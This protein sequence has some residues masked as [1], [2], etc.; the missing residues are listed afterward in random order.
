MKHISNN[1]NVLV[2]GATGLVGGHVVEK[3]LKEGKKVFALQRKKDR[4]SYFYS[5]GL[6]KHCK[7][8][9]LNILNYKKLNQL[10]KRHKIS[11]IIHLAAQLKVVTLYETFRFNVL[12]TLNLLEI[13]KNNPLI[14]GLVLSSTNRAY[15][16]KNLS[17]KEIEQLCSSPY[18][19]SKT[20]AEFMA[21]SYMENFKIPV[22]IAR[23]GNV[24][25][26]GDRQKRIVPEILKHLVSNKT[27]NLKVS[28]SARS[29]IYVKDVAEGLC[30]MINK[31][32][33]VS[34][35]T[36]GFDT[37]RI[38]TVKNLIKTTGQVL[39]LEPK[40]RVLG[41]IKN[42][43]SY[44]QLNTLLAG[45]ILNWRPKIPFENGIKLTY[46]WYRQKRIK[47]V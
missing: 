46:D 8:F 25:G 40:Y 3:L 10:I 7:V 39:G 15:G 42:D 30:N 37:K 35:R 4:D 32:P 38:F 2:T 12:G 36:I 45:K 14:K 19:L 44:K 13:T 18:D 31:F 11:F 26:P 20:T 22:V 28:S 47:V 43:I 29:Y 41:Q 27:L 34:G 23:F 5:Q 9:N 21:K 1:K 16:E 33:D 6:Y 24:Y 17:S